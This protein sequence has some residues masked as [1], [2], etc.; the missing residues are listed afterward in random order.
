LTFRTRLV[1]DLRFENST[2]GVLE[3]DADKDLDA[4]A[5]EVKQ[6]VWPGL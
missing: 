2:H 6:R 3:I 1:R 4:V 5:L